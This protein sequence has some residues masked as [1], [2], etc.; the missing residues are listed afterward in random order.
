VFHR[1][2]MLL[3]LEMT[4]V[5][6][7]S[8]EHVAVLQLWLKNEFFFHSTKTSAIQQTRNGHCKK[9]KSVQRTSGKSL[10]SV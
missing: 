3:L 6:Q 5:V 2:A 10:L 4:T 9:Q 8:P 1:A 7:C